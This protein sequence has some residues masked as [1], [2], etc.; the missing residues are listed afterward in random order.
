LLAAAATA[1]A[2]EDGGEAT[3]AR[4]GAAVYAE[5]CQACH[6]PQGEAKGEG[7]VFAAITYDPETI[8]DVITNGLD[9]IDQDDVAMPPYSQMSGGLLSD[10]QIDYLIAYMETWG[11]DDV[12]ALPEPNIHAAVD[13]VPNQ[14]GDPQRGAVIYATYCYGCHGK[15]GQGRVP[16][17]FPR[18]HMTDYVLAIVR[19]GHDNKY[20]PAFGKEAGGPLDDPQLEDLT[21]YMASWSLAEEEAEPASPKG[22]STLLVI[23]GIAAI[24]FVGWTYQ[25]REQ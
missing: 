12:P 10:A 19:D 23:L 17:N 11:T 2:Q 24:L 18:L 15:E 6:G 5:F 20:M 25:G 14:E 9:S 4:R 21:A 8:R 3:A 22:F 7:P 16:P 13:R 1:Y